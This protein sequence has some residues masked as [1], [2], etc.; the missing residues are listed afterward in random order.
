MK[1]ILLISYSDNENISLYKSDE[2]Y[3]VTTVWTQMSALSLGIVYSIFRED[4]YTRPGLFACL[5]LPS[6]RQDSFTK[7]TLSQTC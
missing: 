6:L 2:Q 5:I 3:V 4:F 1:H 7:S